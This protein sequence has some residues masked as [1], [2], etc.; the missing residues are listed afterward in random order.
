MIVT[1]M[2]RCQVLASIPNAQRILIRLIELYEVWE[3]G[4]KEKNS[5]MIENLD[6]E[7]IASDLFIRSHSVARSISALCDYQLLAKIP[8][9]KKG[10]KMPNSY[11]LTSELIKRYWVDYNTFCRL[12]DQ[13]VEQVKAIKL[14]KE[15]FN[16]LKTKAKKQ[17]AIYLI[18]E[19]EHQLIDEQEQAQ[20][21]PKEQAQAKAQAIPKEKNQEKRKAK[22]QTILKEKEQTHQEQAWQQEQARQEQAWQQEQARQEQLRQNQEQLRQEQLRQK[23]LRQEQLQQEL[24]RQEQLRQDQARQ[25]QLRQEQL[26]QDQA[27]QEQ[28]RQEQLRQALEDK[29]KRLS[30]IAFREFKVDQSTESSIEN[31]SVSLE[32]EA[33]EHIKL[34]LSSNKNRTSKLFLNDN[35]QL[36]DAVATYKRIQ[37]EN[38]CLRYFSLDN[39]IAEMKGIE[40]N[41]KDPKRY[42]EESYDCIVIVTRH[43]IRGRNMYEH[44][45]DNVEKAL[46]LLNELNINVLINFDNKEKHK[47]LSNFLDISLKQ[48][49]D[50]NVEDSLLPF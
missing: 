28:L 22:T 33:I 4:K 31:I 30:K 36:A 16:E 12:N 47:L 13:P 43:I 5:L 45:L 8:Q 44:E 23:Q 40:K 37:I 48:E 9:I 35:K 41:G 2:N 3:K 17:L 21:M 42:F 29:K 38:R 1:N 14:T 6:Y 24:L 7:T 49:W 39:F 26:R 50:I 32:D 20:A 10:V 11:L 46:N 15:M 19:Q 25:E 18:D 34:F 27:R